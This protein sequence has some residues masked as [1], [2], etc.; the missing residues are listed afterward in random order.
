MFITLRYHF[1]F[2]GVSNAIQTSFCLVF[3]GVFTFMPLIAFVSIV[4]N[5]KKLSDMDQ[6]AKTGVLYELLDLANGRIVL[7]KP[8]FYLIR[9]LV[10]ALSVV[11]FDYFFLQVILFYIQVIASLFI[12]GFIKTEKI[13]N[14]RESIT[15]ELMLLLTMYACLC[16]SEWLSDPQIKFNISYFLI[17]GLLLSIG[18][19]LSGILRQ[20]GFQVR[21]KYKLCYARRKLLKQRKVLKVKLS[22][23]YK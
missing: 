15:N 20:V 9:R 21:K 2:Q 14:N 3:A 16:F 18:T 4:I 22:A 17:A 1:T 10:L 7:I 13:K 11:V 19:I 8:A 12:I 23:T 5:F 6:I